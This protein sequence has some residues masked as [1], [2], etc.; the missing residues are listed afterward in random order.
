MKT[1]KPWLVVLLVFIA[2]FTGG[3]VVTR[4]VVRQVVHNAVQDPD[5]MR[6]MIEKRM[7]RR[8]RLDAAQRVK[9]GGILRDTQRELRELRGEFQP[10]FLNIVT[11]AQSEISATLTSE[12]KERFENLQAENRHW[13]RGR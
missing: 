4:G 5:F 1:L 2:G 11:Q 9:V 10:R 12:Q 3:V 13:W 7:A 8:L 6:M